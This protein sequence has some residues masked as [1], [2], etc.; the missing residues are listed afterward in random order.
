METMWRKVLLIGGR[1]LPYLRSAAPSALALG[2]IALLVAT[3][4]LG[5][6]WPMNGEYPLAA[7]QMRALVTLGVILVVAMFWGFMLA[8]RLRKVDS[9]KAE[10]EQELEDPILPYERRQ[11]RLLDRQLAL[12]KNNLPGRKGVYRLPWYLVMG[13]E[14]AGKS[15]LIQRSGQTYTLTN[16]TR[17]SRA[18]HNPIGFDWWIGDDGVLIDPDGELL[19]QGYDDGAGSELPHRLW[20]HFIYWLE[21]NR[22][23]RPLNGVVLTVD[24]ASLS[25]TSE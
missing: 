21:R 2:V 16:V 7:W 1:L 19:S 11:Q 22:P 15:S 18:D 20:Q 14:D 4:W 13:L 10:A 8:G 17:N 25:V 23:Q 9:A 24:V 5:P 6:S 12:L 3:W